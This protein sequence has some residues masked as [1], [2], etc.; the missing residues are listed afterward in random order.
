MG[1]YYFNFISLN[2]EYGFSLNAK[3]DSTHIDLGKKYIDVC[4]IF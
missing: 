4:H 3:K 2:K 1:I